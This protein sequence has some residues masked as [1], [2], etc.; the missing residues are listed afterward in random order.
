MSAGP[1]QQTRRPRGARPHRAAR[2]VAGIEVGVAA[3]LVLLDLLVP[4][5]VLLAMAGLSLALRRTGPAS[6]G[7]VRPGRPWRLAGEMLVAAAVLALVDVGL[8]IPALEHVTGERQDTSGF[9]ELQGNL[10]L[11]AVLLVLSWTLAAFAEEAAFRGYLL[12]RTVEALGGAR[13]AMPAAI[14]ATAVLFAAIHTEQGAV[15]VV[16]AGFDGAVLGG[17]RWWKGTV[18]A[19]VLAHGFDNTIGFV[20]FFL[21]GP[22]GGLW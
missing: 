4:S 2:A 15:G 18:W 16:T 9:A 14:L 8:V 12:T 17:L 20:A 22:V 13:W 7:L 19:P 11:L 1:V 6:L 5:L 3:V 10:A 21:V